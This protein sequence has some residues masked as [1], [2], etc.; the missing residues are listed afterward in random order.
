MSGIAGS[1]LGGNISV[2]RLS[3]TAILLFWRLYFSSVILSV[4]ACRFNVVEDISKRR[5]I[6]V[7]LNPS[8][9]SLTV[10]VN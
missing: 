1:A 10:L 9:A 8:L 6:E 5:M 4:S 7:L 3:L 2:A